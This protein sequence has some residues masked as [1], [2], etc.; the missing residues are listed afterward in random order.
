MRR[1]V[2]PDFE[3]QERNRDD[4]LDQREVSW[5]QGPSFDWPELLDEEDE[6]EGTW[7]V[8]R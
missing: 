6:Q 3:I 5:D 1:G 4:L 2:D 8:S 7:G